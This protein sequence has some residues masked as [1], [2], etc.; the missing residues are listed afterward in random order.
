MW[1]D[2]SW[3]NE[4]VPRKT[5]EVGYLHLNP[6]FF[7]PGGVMLSQQRMHWGDGGSTPISPSRED[8]IGVW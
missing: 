2:R 5:Q 4:S 7:C 3:F 6:W 8:S 1:E